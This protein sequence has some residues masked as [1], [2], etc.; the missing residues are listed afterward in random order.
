MFAVSDV[1]VCISRHN[2]AVDSPRQSPSVRCVVAE[3]GS[4]ELGLVSDVHDV[5]HRRGA[6]LKLVLDGG[7][8]IRGKNRRTGQGSQ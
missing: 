6:T 4:P 7:E 1:G 3:V 5:V 2:H 8:C